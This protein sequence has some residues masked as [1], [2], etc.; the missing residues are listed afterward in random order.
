MGDWTVGGTT[1]EVPLEGAEFGVYRKDD[2]DT[3]VTTLVTGEDGTA[4]SGGLDAGTYIL[5]ETKAPDGFASNDKTY[6]VTVENNKTDTTW[7]DTPIENV[8]NEGRFVLKKYDGSDSAASDD[9][10]GLTGA[11]FELYRKDDDGNWVYYNEETPT[12]TVTDATGYTSG[13]LEPGDYKLVE[14]QAPTHVVTSG[15]H[16]YN[17]S[18][19]L[20]DTPIYFS[21]QAGVTGALING[22]V[23]D[24]VGGI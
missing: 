10:T 11:V 3:L 6:E 2:P 18:F 24:I 5:K 4:I 1:D 22:T 19:D 12:F 21:I 15:G 7:Y 16:E 8:A 14:I 9:L 23:G 17:I 13:Y 20:D